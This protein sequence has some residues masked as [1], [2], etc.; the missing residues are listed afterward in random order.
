MYFQR[1]SLVAIIWIAKSPIIIDSLEAV[2]REHV[3]YAK[4]ALLRGAPLDC[5][6]VKVA[7]RRCM[8]RATQ[9]DHKSEIA[10]VCALHRV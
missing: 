2:M 6:E 7:P 4:K 10:E 3:A 5:D 8:E 1:L 9:N